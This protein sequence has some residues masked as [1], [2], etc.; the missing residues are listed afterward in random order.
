MQ[1]TNLNRPESHKK[2]AEVEGHLNVYEEHLSTLLTELE[3]HHVESDK[4]REEIL[5]MKVDKM[6]AKKANLLASFDHNDGVMRRNIFGIW[7]HEVY[8][9]RY[10]RAQ[11]WVHEERLRMQEEF[12]RYRARAQNQKEESLKAERDQMEMERQLHRK[13]IEQ[14]DN[15]LAVS[16]DE[17]ALRRRDYEQLAAKLEKIDKFLRTVADQSLTVQELALSARDELGRDVHDAKR[18]Q[19]LSTKFMVV[20]RRDD[21]N[22]PVAVKSEDHLK[23]GLHDILQRTDARYMP[24]LSAN[25]LAMRQGGTGCAGRL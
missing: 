17:A 4:L 24:R 1:R 23:N 9:E 7:K 25:P 6:N 18:T 3:A 12:A 14:R 22:T 2:L 11:T 19:S 10:A 13:A 8:T 5:R 15:E 20:Q 21:M 16:K